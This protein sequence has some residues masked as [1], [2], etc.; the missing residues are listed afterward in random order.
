LPYRQTSGTIS[1]PKKFIAVFGQP[2]CAKLRATPKRSQS[3]SGGFLMKSGNDLCP[4]R[5]RHP[6][7]ALNET[8]FGL[9]VKFDFDEL[10][11]PKNVTLTSE[12]GDAPG[13]MQSA[14]AEILRPNIGRK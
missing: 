8:E 11:R 12:L 3:R 7:D 10:M 4:I 1:P 14:L 5:K 13:E 9:I 2:V 6:K